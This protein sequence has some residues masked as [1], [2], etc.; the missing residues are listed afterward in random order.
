MPKLGERGEHLRLARKVAKKARV[1]PEEVNEPTVAAAGPS[2]QPDGVNDS[3]DSN[4][5]I[6]EVLKWDPE[7]M[8]EEFTA[9]WVASLTRDYLY[10]FLL[11]LLQVLT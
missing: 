6:E 8:I 2:R 1:K 5:D 11:L 10:S 4:F 3:S 7:A 9:D